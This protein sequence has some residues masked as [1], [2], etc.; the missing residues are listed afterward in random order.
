MRA[1]LLG[2]VALPAFTASILGL[3]LSAYNVS[4]MPL[5]PIMTYL[6][7]VDREKWAEFKQAVAEEGHTALWTINGL[8]DEYLERARDRKRAKKDD[9]K[10]T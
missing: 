8:I 4:I 3:T 5:L 6:L 10:K 1:F 9:R 2:F 7:K